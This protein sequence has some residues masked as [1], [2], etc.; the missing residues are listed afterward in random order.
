MNV[1][2]LVSI[3]QGP[4]ADY[5]ISDQEF[6]AAN[7]ILA[8]GEHLPAQ[9]SNVSRFWQRREGEKVGRLAIAYYDVF[10]TRLETAYEFLFSR[11]DENTQQWVR[12]SAPIITERPQ[13][14]NALGTPAASEEE[15]AQSGSDESD[16]AKG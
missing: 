7:A 13:G 8:A 2:A 15:V 5:R 6:V 9:Y 16:P 4:S 14:L 11:R 1:S 12:L 3:T 10:G